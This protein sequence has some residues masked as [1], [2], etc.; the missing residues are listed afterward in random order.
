MDGSLVGEGKEQVDVE[1]EEY[2][3]PDGCFPDGEYCYRLCSHLTLYSLCVKLTL[4][5]T[6]LTHH[7]HFVSPQPLCK[8]SVVVR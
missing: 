5:F 1:L 7:H 8:S 2:I 4:H 6:L 3:E